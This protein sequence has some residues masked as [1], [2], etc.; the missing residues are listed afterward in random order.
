MRLQETCSRGTMGHSAKK[1]MNGLLAA[2]LFI[3]AGALPFAPS[4]DD[5][6]ENLGI[7]S[8]FSLHSLRPECAPAKPPCALASDLV[9]RATKPSSQPAVEQTSKAV[10]QLP[11]RLFD[12]ELPLRM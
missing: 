4:A 12:A 8:V 3:C 7:A 6:D 5:T 2:V 9:I 1:L 10:F 11:P